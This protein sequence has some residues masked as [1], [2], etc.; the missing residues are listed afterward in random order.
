M[1]PTSGEKK[2][3]SLITQNGEIFSVNLSYSGLSRNKIK[4]LSME[5]VYATGFLVLRSIFHFF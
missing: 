4:S 2:S 5:V 1:D 3:M